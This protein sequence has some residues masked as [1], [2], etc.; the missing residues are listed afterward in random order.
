MADIYQ[1]QGGKA[2]L[3]MGENGLAP[4]Y[5]ERLNAVESVG[6]D[7]TQSKPGIVERVEALETAN[8]AQDEAISTAQETASTAQTAA[9]AAIASAGAGL[10]KS[11]Q[12]LALATVTTSGG[13]AGPTANATPAFGATF[14]VPKVVYDKYGRVTGHTNYTVKIPAASTSVTTATKATTV[15]NVVVVHNGTAYGG[16]T[17]N[18]LKYTFPSGGTWRYLLAAQAYYKVCGQVAGGT[19]LTESTNN[20]FVSDETVLIGIRV[21]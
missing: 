8:I 2:V 12:A 1:N 11:G 3:L 20:A 9:S 10:T 13:T 6:Q 15:P 16:G 18:V 19:T 17:V 14:T 21:A 7:W 4:Q 5:V